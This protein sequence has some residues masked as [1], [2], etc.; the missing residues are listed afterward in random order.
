VKGEVIILE[1]RAAAKQP[2]MIHLLTKPARAIRNQGTRRTTSKGPRRASLQLEC[3]EGRDVPSASPLDQLR[4]DTAHLLK[5]FVQAEAQHST[6]LAARMSQDLIA[7][8]RDVQAGQIRNLGSDLN[9]INRDIQ[10]E[11]FLSLLG[12][13]AKGSLLSNSAFTT[14]YLQVAFDIQRLTPVA[15]AS[16]GQAG[17]GPSATLAYSAATTFSNGWIASAENTG[18]GSW[19]Y[20]G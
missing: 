20:S 13:P 14:A 12:N 18:P 10:T 3:L 6:L 4:A 1:S 11:A 5:D 16:T 2:P 8:G 7:L 17:F 15:Q 19:N 9:R